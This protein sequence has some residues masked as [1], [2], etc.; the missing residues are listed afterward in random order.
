MIVR[1]HRW[2][3][4]VKLS[5]TPR[6]RIAIAVAA[7]IGVTAAASITLLQRDL[8]STSGHD[9]LG[10]GVV[11]L[12]MPVAEPPLPEMSEASAIVEARADPSDLPMEA[13]REVSIPFS[14]Q[15]EVA[16]IA[17][18]PPVSSSEEPQAKEKSAKAVAKIAQIEGGANF[19]SGASITQKR[20]GLL[21]SG[22]P[23]TIR[24]KEGRWYAVELE[25]GRKG[26]VHSRLVTKPAEP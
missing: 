13:A 15:S 12:E 18:L 20:L 21:E 19:R 3:Q 9:G 11:R 8:Y 26:Y 1:P 5:V 16:E 2:L 25:D 6:G 23:L 22:E 7:L 4:G 24:S 17:S 14:K 10:G